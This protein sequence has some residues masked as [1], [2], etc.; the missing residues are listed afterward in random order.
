MG[1]H[2]RVANRSSRRVGAAE[3]AVPLRAAE[4]GGRILRTNRAPAANLILDLD[5]DGGAVIRSAHSIR[6]DT[7]QPVKTV[8]NSR[9]VPNEGVSDLVSRSRA[10]DGVGIRPAAEDELDSG[11]LA[12]Q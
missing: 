11:D 8:W 5:S 1:S 9:T 4:E 3:G 2:R 10:D 6:G 12:C 7:L